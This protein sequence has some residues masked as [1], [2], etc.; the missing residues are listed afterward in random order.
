[1]APVFTKTVKIHT[2]VY[3]KQKLLNPETKVEASKM[4]AAKTCFP[5][6]N[7]K[8]EYFYLKGGLRPPLVTCTFHKMLDFI[9]MCYCW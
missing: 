4:E 7:G 1:M 8:N 6:V 9:V 2:Y 3:A 5:C